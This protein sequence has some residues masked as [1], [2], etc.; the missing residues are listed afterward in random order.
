MSLG[1]LVLLH[2]EPESIN[3]SILH[4]I[5][6]ETRAF[7]TSRFL[8]S[9]CSFI[10]LSNYLFIY[11][12]IPSSVVIRNQN[13]TVITWNEDIAVLYITGNCTFHFRINPTI[14]IMFICAHSRRVVA[15]F[16]NKP[17]AVFQFNSFFTHYIYFENQNHCK[18]KRRLPLAE[19]MPRLT[20]G[21]L[22]AIRPIKCNLSLTEKS[23]LCSGP[24]RGISLI[25]DVNIYSF[26][27]WS[28]HYAMH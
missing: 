12:P 13:I 17:N 5:F 14:F 21:S 4:I 11:V 19:T 3:M 23:C 27:A 18:I 28:L 16:C 15:R 24:T 10:T 9:N 20:P 7:S 8:G 22:S 6:G 2:S 1:V 25:A 26:I